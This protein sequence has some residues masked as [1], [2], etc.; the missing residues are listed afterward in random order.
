MEVTLADDALRI[1][2]SFWLTFHRTLR[3]PDDG[4]RYPL[5]PGLGRFPVYA[6]APYA[7]H[8]PPPAPGEDCYVIPMYQREALWLGF[9]N[10]WP[11]LAVKIALGG[12]NV[13]SARVDAHGLRARPRNYVVCP[14]QLWLDGIKTGPATIRQFVAVA[15][16]EGASVEAAI[17]GRET[18]GGM[19]IEFYAPRPGVVLERPLARPVYGLVKQMSPRMGLG[20]GGRM[21]QKIYPDPHGIETWCESPAARLCIHILNSAQFRAITG[22]DP[23][24]TPIDAR[25]YAER[26]L[27]WFRLYDE[28]MG[29]VPAP[30]AF[31][32]IATIAEHDRA[33]GHADEPG[34]AIDPSSIRPAVDPKR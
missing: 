12:V 32:H 8:F 10:D 25:A 3:I 24:P 13:L 33:Q 23:P 4:R 31:E 9:G 21:T 18:R 5:P 29:D 20:A 34:I 11:P 27:P 7:A 1:G 17:S 2:E 16:G 28:H 26:G 6:C 19:Q 14:E 22:V 30:A 15:L